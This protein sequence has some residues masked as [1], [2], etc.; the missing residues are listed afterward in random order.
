MANEDADYRSHKRAGNGRIAGAL[1]SSAILILA[2]VGSAMVIVLSGFVVLQ[3]TI[4]GAGRKGNTSATAARV[5]GRTS[6]VC[7]VALNS[8]PITAVASGFCISAPVPVARAI[9]TKPSEA[10]VGNLP[11]KGQDPRYQHPGSAHR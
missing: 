6:N 2:H 8:P 10:G 9:G 4:G 3:R 1:G 11:L 5:A 7:R